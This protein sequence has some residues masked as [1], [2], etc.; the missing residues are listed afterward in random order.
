MPL[1]IT[2]RAAKPVAVAGDV[3]VVGVWTRA[4]RSKKKGALD[5]LAPFERALGGGLSTLLQREE[6]GGKKDQ[7]V[8][9][10]TLGKLPAL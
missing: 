10:Q 1:Q 5:P 8:R 4:L 7:S 6:F 3:I 9:V 2:V